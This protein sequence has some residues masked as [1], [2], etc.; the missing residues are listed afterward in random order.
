[1]TR[2]TVVGSLNCDLVVRVPVLPQP[3]QTVVGDDLRRG[4]GG[5]GGNQAVAAR[6]LGAEVVFIGAVGDDPTGADLLAWQR[7]EGVDVERVVVIPQQPSGAAFITVR[8]DG[9]NTIT[10]LPG[11]NGRLVPVHL[12]PHRA[13]IVSADMLLLQ[14]ELSCPVS[15]AAAYIAR[16]AGVGVLLNAAPLPAPVSSS[17]RALVGAVSVL[18]V[19]EVEAA[20][21]AG[22]QAS[23]AD[24]VRLG[25]PL[26]VLTRGAGG[27]E[28]AHRDGST[29][30]VPAFAVEAVDAVGAGDTFT[31]AL[32]LELAGQRT[33]AEAVR[34][35]CA[36]AALAT[37][38]P[39][40][41]A[42]MPTAA[43]VA[44]FLADRPH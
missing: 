27:A 16:A 4:P 30:T 34:R 11:A 36:A 35:A 7:A 39:G 2:L 31:A 17:V 20:A 43:E 40:A 38:R 29:G 22:E 24:L 28:W 12:D 21:L 13:A 1:M 19:N 8:P 33:P 44:A 41:Q 32:A 14:L 26:A 42:A 25:P 10:V 9:E 23:A 6:R 37:T 5:K 3:G 18:V 15:A